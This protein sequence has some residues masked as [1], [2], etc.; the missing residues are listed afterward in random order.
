MD[1]QAQLVFFAGFV[2]ICVA[3]YQIGHFLAHFN[4]P[5]ITGYLLVGALAGPYLLNLLPAAAVENL[6]FVDSVS[7]AVIAFV[8]GSEL[9]LKELRSRARA[10]LLIIGGIITAAL[11]L[12]GVALFFLTE[13][14]PFVQ[15]MMAAG[16]LDTVGRAAIAILGA[17]I[18]LALSPPSTIAVIKEVRARGPFTKTLLGV[19]VTM[20]VVIIVL[21]AIAAAL[22]G[23][24]LNGSSIPASFAPIL[25][26]DLALAAA[27]GYIIGRVAEAVLLTGWPRAVKTALVLL[28]GYAVFAGGAVVPALTDTYLGVKI[29][30]E[31]LLVAMIA[32]FTVTNFSRARDQFDGILHDIGPWVYVAFFTLTGIGLKLD[33]LLSTLGIAAVLFAVRMAAIYI[34]AF[35][36]T[37][38]ASEPPRFRRLIGLGLI[39]QAGIALG[40]AREVSVQFPATLGSEFAT[41]I[42][43][44]VVLNELFGPLFLKYALRRAG[45]THEPEGAVR[46]GTREA[47]ILGIEQQSLSLARQLSANG[48]GVIVADTNREQVE[49]LAAEDV[50]ERHIPDISAATLRTLMG[51]NT[52]ALVA[53]MPDD[54]DNLQACEIAYEEF[55]CRRMVARLNDIKLAERFRELGVLVVDQTSAMVNL[56]DQSVR[57]PQTTA[58]LLH[59]DARYDIV[60]IT[61][62][63]RDAHNVLLRDLRLPNDVLVVEIS[64]RGQNIVPS[65]YTAIHQYDEM[66]LLGS[67]DSLREVTLRLGY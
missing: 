37:T 56:L 2:I 1:L 44:V 34:G 12:L 50:D 48:W 26:I 67:P 19:T 45:E 14:I 61:V 10:I 7:L 6:R 66:T 58:L 30:V 59:S 33:I 54:A 25:V 3:S 18:L 20:D 13:S 4:L 11:V 9:Y 49:R 65:G 47:V 32:G 43:S 40:L 38:V 35:S 28:I 60:Q 55:G 63:E 16:T 27:A 41:L 39:T 23:A 29:H 62:T 8:A 5:H 17:T 42:I 24:L 36:G 53:L 22:A 64:R 51:P 15:E 46:D 31:S 21:F 57:A 52:D